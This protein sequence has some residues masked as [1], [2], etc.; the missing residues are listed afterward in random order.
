MKV[1]LLLTAVALLVI[2][3]PQNFTQIVLV[4]DP[5]AP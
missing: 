1:L 4:R 2:S 3:T 5:A